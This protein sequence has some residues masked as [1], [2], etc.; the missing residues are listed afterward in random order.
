MMI[1][2]RGRRSSSNRRV[3]EAS[4]IAVFGRRGSGKST[5]VKDMIASARRVIVIDTLGEYVRD[6]GYE[7]AD[8]VAQV[9]DLMVDGWKSGYRIAYC[10][11][12]DFAAKGHVLADFLWQA[13]HRYEGRRTADLVT[14]V[15]E[16]AN[17]VIPNR[18]M[19]AG[20]DA[21]LR[22]A[23]QGRHRGIGITMVSQRPALVSADIR[24]Q[25]ADV[26]YFGLTDPL[27]CRVVDRQC[28]A[29]WGDKARALPEHSYIKWSNGLISQ[30]KNPPIKKSSK[31]RTS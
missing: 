28:G 21:M 6:C 22:L 1:P 24:S 17:L 19:R 8:T 13:R 4:C 10:P 26:Y 2:C 15:V 5:R 31:K 20:Q 12:R 7:R 18:Q 11:V 9:R 16:E 27:D 25:A 29:G 3:T 23:L 14:V 30:G